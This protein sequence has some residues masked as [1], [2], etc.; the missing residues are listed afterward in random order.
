MGMIIDATV[1]PIVASDAGQLT[2]RLDQTRAL[3]VTDAHG[4]LREAAMRG[5]LYTGMT[6][7][8]GTTV[9]AGNNSPIAAAAASILS[10]YNPLGT[11]VNLSL[12]RTILFYVSGTPAAGG[13]VYNYGFSQNITAVQNNGGV[14]G[15][16]PVS[17]LVSGLSG[18]GKIY[19][20]T[21]LTGSGAQILYRPIGGTALFAG[22]LAATTPGL[23]VVEQ[24]DGEIEAPP[25]GVV[26]VASPG[27]GTTLIVGACFVWEE[28][29]LPA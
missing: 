25:G 1:G 11:K 18:T 7:I 19:T 15:A 13:W 29:P 2:L 10:L 24:V 23:G 22:A 28:I 16:A 5:K 14:A 6:A 21:A 26:S 27:T 8:G 4:R 9:V 12:L 20:Q 17:G 3:V